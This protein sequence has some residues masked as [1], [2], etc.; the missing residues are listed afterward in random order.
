MP[1][2]FVMFAVDCVGF[3]MFIID[4]VDFLL[5]TVLPSFDFAGLLAVLLFSV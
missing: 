1:F 3:V 2:D 5:L 4:C